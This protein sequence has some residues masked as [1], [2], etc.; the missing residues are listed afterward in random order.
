MEKKQRG[1]ENLSNAQRTAVEY[2]PGPMLITAGAGSGKTRTLTHRLIHLIETGIAP[3]T[4]VAITFTNKAAGEIKHRL[5]PTL[6]ELHIPEDKMP[7]LGTFHSYGARILR[8]EARAFGRTERF[9]IFDADDSLQ[10][11]KKVIDAA[12][13]RF[14]SPHAKRSLA[15]KLQKEFSRIKNELNYSDSLPKDTKELFQAYEELLRSQN[16]FDFDDLIEKPVRLFERHPE[17]LARY[18]ENARYILVDEYQDINTSQYA[19]VKLL[20]KRHRNLNVV[21]DDQQSIYR[22]RGSDFR[23]FLNFERDWPDAKIIE[24]GENYRSTGNIVRAAASVIDHNT[25]QRQKKLW[26]ENEEGGSIQIIGADSAEEEAVRITHAILSLKSEDLHDIAVLYRTNAQSRALEQAFN[27]NTVSY[28]IFGGLRFYD[29]KEIRDIVAAVRY[30]FNPLDTISLE[31]LDKSFRKATYRRLAEELPAHGAKLSPLELI[32][33]ILKTTDYET[34]LKSK[35]Q[36]AEERMENVRE[37]ISFAGSFETTDAFLERILLLQSNDRPEKTSGARPIK[38]MTVHLAKGL[39]FDNIFLVGVNEGTMPHHRSLYLKD[40]LEEERRL[41]YVAMTRAR[42]ALTISF[43]GTASRFLNEIPPELIEFT[44][45]SHRL[46]GDIYDDD[47][48]LE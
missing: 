28:E 32:G 22:F 47:L 3:D 6:E 20:S 44:G 38:M 26:T 43:Y 14:S 46:I 1:T 48:Y 29:R 42:K 25:I 45:P 41:M 7:F 18:Q 8:R 13:V 35:F 40:E 30:S 34:M 21:G 9:V 11:I 4:I 19:L 36:N 17:A 23:N 39:E 31:R 12:N 5:R 27:L 16:A 24:L 10:V 15:L 33:Y 37:L 2:G